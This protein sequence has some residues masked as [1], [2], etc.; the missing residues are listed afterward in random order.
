MPRL[1]ISAPDGK[2]GILE[3]NKP[4][5]TIGRGNANDLVLNDA[6]ISRLHAVVK[7]HAAK[8]LIADRGS[9]NGVIVN[10]ERISDEVELK[11]G[12]V[13]LLGRHQLR[14]EKMDERTLLV[15][16]GEIP[17]TINHILHGRADRA[18]PRDRSTNSGE[19]LTEIRRRVEKLERENY[20]LTVLYDAGQT[21]HAR[22]S[23]ED[24]G[25]HA[26]A[27]AFRIEGVERGFAMLFDE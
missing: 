17:S 12:D 10:G 2:K 5:V 23:V 25:E 14:L 20:L 26:I 21:L 18:A 27:L 19:A 1:I 3:L 8:V 16:K 15:R 7:L 4:V 22:L 11:N 13:A 9:T 24:I 6:E